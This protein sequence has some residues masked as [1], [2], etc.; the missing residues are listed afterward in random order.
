M[1]QLVYISF[2]LVALCGCADAIVQKPSEEISFELLEVKRSYSAGGAIRLRFGYQ[3]KS[4]VL[5]L[6]KNAYG[7]T[8]LE[9]Q[10]SETE[11]IF[12]L[13]QSFN[14]NAGLCKWELVVNQKVYNT[15]EFTIIPNTQNQTNLETYLGPRSINA[16]NRDYTMMV[17]SPTDIYDN[18]VVNGTAV[19]IKNQF[20]NAIDTQTLKTTNLLAWQNI[21]ATEKAGRLLITAS[22]NGTNTKELTSIVFP[23]NATDFDIDF[24][25]NHSYADGNQIIT[26]STSIIV[27]AYGNVISDGTL[28]S[29]IVEDSLGNLLRTMGTTLGG[30]AEAKLLHPNQK[31]IW[32]VT[33]YVTGSAQSNA[34]RVPF[35]AAVKKYAISFSNENKMVTIGPIQSFMGQLIPDGMPIQLAIFKDGSIVMETKTSTAKNGIGQFTLPLDFFPNGSYTLKTTVSGI[36]KTQQISID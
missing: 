21:R 17:V 8:A 9:P 11:I 5:L 7:I 15:G 36:T 23:A 29:F 14:Q 19:V 13:P 4:E 20:E 22:C 3:Q 32:M 25:R 34:I 10:I 2:L 31:E 1:R 33:G 12:E 18:P 30:K 16:G 6:V 26:F 35:E 27:D 24:Q 28:V